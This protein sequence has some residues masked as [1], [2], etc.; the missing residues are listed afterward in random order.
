MNIKR[1]LMSLICVASMLVSMIPPAMASSSIVAF[2][3]AEG[4]G[5]YATGGR[6]GKV[7]HV[8]NLNDSGTGSFRD[9]VSGSNRIVVFDVGGTIELESD[10]VV[11]GNITVAGQTAPGGGGITL[12]GGKIGMGGDNIIIR[13][14]SSRPGENGEEECDAWGGSAGSNSIID[15]CSIGW[16]NDEQFGLYSKNMHQTVQYSIIGP[17]N[18]ISYHSK[19]CHGFGIMF[20]KGQ[21]SWHHNMIAHNVSRN[22][23]GKVEKQNTMDFVNNV[24]YNWGYQTGYGTLGRIN[25]VGNY[26]KAGNSTTGSYHFFVRNSGSAIENYL[27]YVTGNKIMKKDGTAYDSS[28]NTDNWNGVGFDKSVYGTDSPMVVQDVNGN[29]ASVVANAQTA[30]EAFAT[31]TAYAGAG[32]SADKRP[33]IDKQVMEEAINGTGYLTGG[34]DFSTVT[35]SALLSAISKY[36]IKEMN[37][38][39]YYPE[40]ITTKEITDTDNDGMSDEWEILRGLNPNKDDAMGDYLGQGYNNIEYY[41]NDLTVDSFPDGVVTV[42]PLSADIGEE[43]YQIRDEL[44]ALS[45]SPTE[46]KKPADLTLP[47]TGSIHGLNISWTSASSAIKLSNNQI[48]TVNRKD[49]DQS[50]TLTAS[51]SHGGYNMSKN[52]TV[53]VVSNSTSW[54]ASDADAGKEAGTEIFDG[55]TT[56]FTA[57]Y[58]SK[59]VSIDGETFTGYISS[60]DTGTFSNGAATGTAF[61]YIAEEN[62]FLTV[63]VTKLGGSN[64]KTLYITEEGAA[65]RDDS[66]AMIEGTGNDVSL[67]AKVQAGKTYYIYVA[68]SKGQFLGIDFSLTAKPEWWRP[69]SAVT[70]GEELMKGLSAM[71]DLKYTEKTKEFEGETFTAN[72]AGSTNP[73]NNGASGASLQYIPSVNG[74]LTVYCKVGSDKTF[75][76]NDADGNIV[77]QWKNEDEAS[78]YV[79]LSGEVKAGTTYYTYIAGSKA[80]FYGVCFTESAESETPVTTPSPTNP[81]SDE[82]KIDKV[83]K[84]GDTI[85]YTVENGDGI[86]LDTYIASYDGDTLKAV[87]KSTNTVSNGQVSFSCEGFDTTNAKIFVWKGM[88]PVYKSCTLYTE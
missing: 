25:Y 18:S 1:R 37:Y 30:D 63:Y 15:H 8:T 86:E 16:A 13:Y 48:K 77:S 32:I 70:A 46:I 49:S 4:A 23:R 7:Y 38:D 35:E 54:R 53:T 68:G 61:K 65:S 43:Y 55:L 36:N 11:K 58:K 21:N 81:P 76:I 24:L 57:T 72:A 64:P 52:F 6:G 44:E 14:V 69:T 29:D 5:K 56:L 66:I 39:E 84:S 78:D 71:E 20:G 80:E 41:I 51:I 60:D 42:S 67:R 3:G 40:P 88:E 50:V 9:A 85:S 62:G 73:S 75:I 74:T 31:V 33:K 83:I 22:F 34:R 45:I 10:V 19:G 47:Q 17:A 59:D 26:L 28:I 27:F 82:I 2:P 79:S 12:K 87:R